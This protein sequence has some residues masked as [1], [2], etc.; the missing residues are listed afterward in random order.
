[1][2][3]KAAGAGG[4][5]LPWLNA[6]FRKIKFRRKLILTYLILTLIPLVSLSVI[7]YR[8]SDSL[9]DRQFAAML[10]ERNMDQASFLSNRLD[11]NNEFIRFT[12]FSPYLMEDFNGQPKDWYSIGRKIGRYFEPVAWYNLVQNQDYARLHIY[13]EYLD[14]SIGSFISPS[15]QVADL[16]WYRQACES[17]NTRWFFAGGELYAVRRIWNSTLDMLLGVIYLEMDFENIMDSLMVAQQSG[18]GAILADRQGNILYAADADRDWS[19][20]ELVSLVDGADRTVELGGTDYYVSSQP[21]PGYD[22]EIYTYAP[23][24]LFTA[25]A[26]QIFYMVFLIVGGCAVL[27]LI[28]IGVFSTGLVKRL[29]MLSDQ[30]SRVIGQ[31]NQSI[32]PMRIK[33]EVGMLADHFGILMGQVYQ[34]ELLQKEE[35]LK[36]LQAQIS[37][38]FLYNTLSLINWKA[39]EDNNEEIAGIAVLISTFYR[40]C[41]NKGRTMISIQEEI[42]NIRAY[43]DLQLIMHNHDFEVEYDIDRA[44]LSGQTINFTLQPLVENAI[45]H[46]LDENEGVR[47]R[48]LIRAEIIAEHQIR[49]LVADNGVGIGRELLETLLNSEGK[50]YGIKNVNQRIKLYFG[51]PYGI[52]LTSEPGRGT[53]VELLIPWSSR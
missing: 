52:R 13:F 11:K 19:D 12:A 9:L 26:G 3:R 36:A 4:R 24:D 27:L 22:W 8:I 5:F 23:N 44:V 7:V 45:I 29:E 1:M 37:P 32:A 46:G 10:S 50:G 25:Q 38:H 6:R 20:A 53:N 33:D 39:L 40:T 14:T 2:K 49:F 47:G 43:I 35:E 51:D 17:P 16:D 21:V 48:L 28:L 30:M 34:S 41:L 31:E 15:A 42:S 18:Y